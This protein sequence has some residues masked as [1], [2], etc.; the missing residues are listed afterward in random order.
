[1]TAGNVDDKSTPNSSENS[2]ARAMELI[3]ASGIL[4]TNVTL[5]QV[6]D[7]TQQLAGTS[8]DGTTQS[9]DTFLFRA[10]IYK[11]ED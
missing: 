7:L 5:G 3:T 10:F 1:M 2:D 4:N 9:K 8:E 6:M 11:H